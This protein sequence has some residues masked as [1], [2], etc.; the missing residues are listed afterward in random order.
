MRF[1]GSM[2][3]LSQP[4]FNSREKILQLLRITNNQ[5]NFIE[6]FRKYE[7]NDYTILMGDEI[8]S[9]DFSELALIF[10]K[11]QAMGLPGFIGILGTRRMN[12]R[13]NIPMVCFA[14]RMITE[15]TTKGTVMPYMNKEHLYA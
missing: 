8:K 1:E 9:R 14:S 4:E 12:Y 10:G 2:G 5:N 6:I 15:M 3:F 11:Y 13:E 7:Q